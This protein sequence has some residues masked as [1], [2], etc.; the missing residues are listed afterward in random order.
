MKAGDFKS[1]EMDTHVVITDNI[2]DIVNHPAFKDFGKYIFPLDNR[3][4]RSDMK[5]SDVEELLPYHTNINPNTVAST[6]NY[7]IDKV[8][9]GEQIFFDFYT[10]KEKQE[11]TTK[12]DTGVFFFKGKPGAKFAIVCP[13]GGFLYVGSIHEGFPHAIKLSEKGYN[14]FVLKYRV[15][16]FADNE[17]IACEDL[18]ALISYIYENAE[19]FQVDTKNYSLWGSSAGARIVANIGTYGLESFVGFQLS[20]PSTIVTAYT[21][22]QN[23]YY[24]D[25][26]T[27]AIVGKNDRI[28]S[29]LAMEKRINNLRK[30]GIDAKLQKYKNLT[31]GFGVGEGTE[32]ESWIDDAIEF[33]EK[34]MTK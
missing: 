32:A 27:F 23:Y 13:G 6:I 30:L 11:E 10:D 15:N 29:H 31:H 33:W 2:I 34:H 4:I 9:S 24:D 22:H 17:F 12:K 14:T 7:M 18:A 21:G 20:K 28:A 8:N 16:Y 5:L 3:R 19:L 26:A 25:P 1:M